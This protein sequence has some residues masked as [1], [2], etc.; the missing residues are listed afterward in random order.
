ETIAT[1]FVPV[2]VV[3]TV[4]NYS[5]NQILILQGDGHAQFS[6]TASYGVGE[7][8]ESIVA[9]DFNGDGKID[10]AVSALNDHTVSFL[11]GNGDGSFVPAATRSDDIARPFGWATWHYPAFMAAGDLNGDGTPEL[12]T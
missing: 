11:L 2:A 10:L 1:D 12:V 3:F 9:M 5:N 4:T 8:P 7:G 6:S